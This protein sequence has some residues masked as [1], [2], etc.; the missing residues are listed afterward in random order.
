MKYNSKKDYSFWKL[1]RSFLHEYLVNV[2]NL[3][4][5]TI[6]AYK[7]SIQLFLHFLEEEKNIKNEKVTFDV[8]NR[9]YVQEFITWLKNKKQ[10]KPKTINLRLTAIKAFLKYASDEDYELKNIYYGIKAIKGQKDNKQPIQYLEKEVTEAILSA[11]ENDTKTHIRNKVLLIVMY[12]TGARVQEIADLKLSSLHLN[13]KSPYVSI[14]GK[15]RKLR[16]VPLTDI[17][18]SHI[19]K[20]IEKFHK[21]SKADDYLFYSIRDNKI[22]QLSTDSISLI[23]KKAAD[24]AR[25]KNDKIPENIHCH[26]LRKTKAMDLYKNGVPL[27]F[28]M[29]L[30][31]HESMSTTSGFYAFATLEMLAEAVNKT[32]TEIQSEE[33]IWRQ[34]K[35]KKSLYSLD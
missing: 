16:N 6:S 26:L 18:T 22:H 34:Y 24:I 23:L 19:K 1:V 2:R 25:K 13:S 5:N 29:Q 10:S 14:I 9:E 33:K 8:F 35:D 20:Y 11:Y 21:N 31:G 4:L 7:D 12:D 30:L 28:I 27:P 15:G 17:T 32:N 3:S